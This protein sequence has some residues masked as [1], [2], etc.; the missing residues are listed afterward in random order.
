VEEQKPTR[1]SS[2]H[3]AQVECEDISKLAMIAQPRHQRKAKRTRNQEEEEEGSSSSS[4]KMYSPTG[5]KRLQQQADDES[6]VHAMNIIADVKRENQMWRR[7]Q[8][9][10]D[11]KR[12]QEMHDI[13]LTAKKQEAE[14]RALRI[15]LEKAEL[16]KK[17]KETEHD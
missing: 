4:Q 16:K 3:D 15:E 10:M 7:Q 14:L 1:T 11:E 6:F 8:A 17:M 12:K 5:S 9:E 13:E 2:A